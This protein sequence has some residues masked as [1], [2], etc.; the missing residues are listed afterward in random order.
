MSDNYIG[1]KVLLEAVVTTSV[2]LT[3]GGKE[4]LDKLQAKLTL[5]GYRYT[6][7]QILDLLIETG[8]E[9]PAELIARAQGIRH[10][11]PDRVI[12]E[13]I[14]SAEHWGRTSW[15]DIDRLAYGRT[16]SR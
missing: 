3:E 1:W 7:E 12:Q 15:R 6:K 16:K 5:L 4:R 11:V 13:I 9:K 8:S 14:D 10:P 2:K